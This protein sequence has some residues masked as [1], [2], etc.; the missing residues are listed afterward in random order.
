[1]FAEVVAFLY[2]SAVERLKDRAWRGRG[3]QESCWLKVCEGLFGS[4]E[5]SFL[6]PGS[7][8]WPEVVILARELLQVL[9][10]RK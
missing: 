4:H 7:D 6:T 5:Y 3:W 2:S 9:E 10:N 1:L 8:A